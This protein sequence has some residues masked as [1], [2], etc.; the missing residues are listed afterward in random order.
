MPPIWV[1]RAGAKV[2]FH[3]KRSCNSKA[4]YGLVI[5][6]ITTRDEQGQI[7]TSGSKTLPSGNQAPDGPPTTLS[8]KGKD[9][10]A[11]LQ[12]DVTRDTTYYENGTPIG[13]R[14]I[15]SVGASFCH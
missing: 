13:E 10:V 8:S 3:E 4:N 2:G 6:E 7:A 1:D 14:D 11:F 5:E 12:A 9:R 15:F